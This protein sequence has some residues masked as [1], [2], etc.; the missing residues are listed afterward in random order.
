VFLKSRQHSRL[1]SSVRRP[2]PAARRV[3][4]EKQVW[5]QRMREIK[6]RTLSSCRQWVNVNGTE[7]RCWGCRG[8]GVGVDSVVPT[9]L[10]LI[11]R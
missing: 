6:P 1:W 11:V 7:T 4:C 9:A 10:M 5:C 3:G 8:W 2:R